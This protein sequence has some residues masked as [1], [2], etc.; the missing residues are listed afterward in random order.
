MRLAI[1]FSQLSMQ[2]LAFFVFLYVIF[3]AQK[4][5]RFGKKID[6]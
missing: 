6:L 2:L 4:D 5:I 1:N 3:F